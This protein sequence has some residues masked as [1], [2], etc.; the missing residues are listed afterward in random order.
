LNDIRR[1]ALAREVEG[2]RRSSQTPTASEVAMTR[3]HFVALAWELRMEYPQPM[4]S[5]TG[6]DLASDYY[7]GRVV[8]WEQAVRATIR[9]CADSNPGFDR[10]RFVR[11]CG[12]QRRPDGSM[13]PMAAPR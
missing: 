9:A 8:G 10:D 7:A 13:Y 11:A 12:W 2:F 3:K 6:G 4:P 5:G 1:R